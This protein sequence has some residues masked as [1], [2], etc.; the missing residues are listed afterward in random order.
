MTGFTA[1]DVP[2]QSGKT[3]A[4]TGA[5]TGLGLETARVLA[6]RGAR[7]VLACRDQGRGEAAMAEIRRETP[8][9]DLALV[10][11]DQGDLASVRGAADRIAAEPRLDVLVNNAGVMMPPLSF[12]RD[13]FEQQFGVNHLGT[14]ALTSLLL[15]KLAETEGAR[16]VITASLAHK[17]KYF[18][19]SNLDAAKGYSRGKFYGQSK[20]ANMLFL[21]ELGRRLKA[22]GSPVIAVGCHPGF[23]STELMRHSGVLK[24]L[25]PLFARVFNTAAMGA[26]PTLQA[27]VGPVTPGGYY[28]PRGIGELRGPSGEA[29]RTALAR[30]EELARELWELSVRMTGIDP[31]I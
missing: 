15:P 22:A 14:F 25:G 10:H 16:V 3:F 6:A 17:Q 12:T 29:A 23:A 2:D 21:L 1:A 9:A 11:L 13:G 30:D 19:L 8:A 20:L 18:D 4:V 27:A 7:V 5:N 24:A 31:G 26:W 28:G